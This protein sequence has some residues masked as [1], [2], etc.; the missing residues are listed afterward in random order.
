MGSGAWASRLPPMPVPDDHDYD[1]EHGYWTRRFLD[2]DDPFGT[3]EYDD[4]DDDDDDEEQEE[5]DTPMNHYPRDDD[6]DDERS[7]EIG[8]RDWHEIGLRQASK[9]RQC[10]QR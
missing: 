2:N 10:G 8:L 9:Q 7:W 3:F 4:D 1:Y 6:D 5:E